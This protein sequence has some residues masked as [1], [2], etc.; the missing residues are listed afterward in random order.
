MLRMVKETLL[1]HANILCATPLGRVNSS[2][3]ISSVLSRCWLIRPLSTP[4]SRGTTSSLCPSRSTRQGR[5]AARRARA[6]RSACE[7]ITHR[8]RSGNMLGAQIKYG[9]YA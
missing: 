5:R 4:T 2:S 7:R 6:R 8:P 3:A 1:N 9:K